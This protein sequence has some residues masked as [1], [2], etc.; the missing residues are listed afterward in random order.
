MSVQPNYRFYAT[1]LDAYQGYINSPALWAKYWGNSENPSKTLEAFEAEQFHG[2]IDKI[3]RVP[4]D[5]EAADRGTVFNEVVDLLI[6]G[7]AQSDR[8]A[9][10]SHKERGVIAAVLKE[11]PGR[12]FIYP[13]EVCQEFANYYPGA[14]PQVYTEAILPTAKGEV[15][16]YGYIDE[17][18]PE[19]VHDIKTT[20]SY[21][22]GKYRENWQHRAYPYCLGQQ[23]VPIEKFEYNVLEFAKN[24][25]LTTY[26][27]QYTYRAD[28]DIE[29]L[30]TVCEELIGFIE[31]H[32]HLITDRKIFNEHEQ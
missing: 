2:L 23:G 30:R 17:L 5:S 7:K 21:S 29:A 18:M 12:V 31:H 13:T 19:C 15:L 20:G 14:T 25:T 8:I 1:L 4:F 28:R 26:T 11:R 32:R 24:G 10:A 27:E 6:L 22:V 16:L 3:N 9:V